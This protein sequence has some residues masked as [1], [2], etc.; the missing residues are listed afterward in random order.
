MVERKVFEVAMISLALAGGLASIEGY[1]RVAVIL[2]LCAFTS[3]VMS[4]I[5]P[6]MSLIFK[7]R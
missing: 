7:T 6:G 2:E 1:K 5:A 4:F 3:G